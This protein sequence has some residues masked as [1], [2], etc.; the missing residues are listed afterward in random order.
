[1]PHDAT[2]GRRLFLYLTRSRLLANGEFLE[3]GDQARMD[4][5]EPLVLEAEEDADF[6][7][8]DV[9]S[10]EGFG[11]SDETLRGRGA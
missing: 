5:C 11:Y 6:I 3:A 7:L 8:I 2:A 1:V 10:W 4:L 9:P